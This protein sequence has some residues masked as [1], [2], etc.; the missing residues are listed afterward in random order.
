MEQSFSSWSQVYRY[1]TS[2]NIR[3]KD[4][5]RVLLKKV[6]SRSI[7]KHGLCDSKLIDTVLLAKNHK[8]SYKRMS[9]PVQQ[10]DQK[11]GD[12]IAE[13]LSLAQAEKTTGVPRQRISDF[14]KG[15]YVSP[16]NNGSWIWKKKEN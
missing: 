3:L 12:V 4:A 13:H 16:E 10:I 8:Y 2:K 5:E 9:I 11:T 14:L 7:A 1:L 15:R 6:V